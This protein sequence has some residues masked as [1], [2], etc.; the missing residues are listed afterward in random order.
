MPAT[1]SFSLLA[2]NRLI[3][4]DRSTD[5]GPTVWRA[6]SLLAGRDGMRVTVREVCEEVWGVPDVVRRT[7]SSLCHRVSEKLAAVGCPLRCGIDGSDVW[8]Y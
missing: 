7:L 4:G 1:V 3:F 5:I 6:L 8:L 2:P